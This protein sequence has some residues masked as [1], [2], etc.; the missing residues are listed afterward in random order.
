[1][2]ETR[3]YE[4]VQLSRLVPNPLNPRKSFEGKQFDELVASV[5]QKGV[6]EPIL[7]RPLNGSFEIV[8][9]ER[10]MKASLAAGIETIP[11]IIQTMS[12]DDAFEAMFIENLHREDLTP[13]EEAQGFKTYIDR[14]GKDALQELCERSGISSK[15][16]I[17]R[18]MILDLPEAALKLW[19]DGKVSLGHLEQLMRLSDKKS[20]NQ[21]LKVISQKD[22]SVEDLRRE[23][24]NDT[25]DLKRAKF[26]RK[27][28]GCTSCQQNSLLQHELFGDE[29][30]EKKSYCL[31]P[32]CFRAKQIAWFEE[33]WGSYA[34]EYN[35]NGFCFGGEVPYDKHRAFTAVDKPGDKCLECEHFVSM[36]NIDGQ[37][38]SGTEC[39]GDKSCF[40]KVTAETTAKAKAEGKSKD[41]ENAGGKGKGKQTAKQCATPSCGRSSSSEHG[42]FFREAFY[43]EALPEKIRA[44]SPSDLMA[45][46]ILLFALF[47]RV[48]EAR[49]HFCEK[50]NCKKVA[51][52]DEELRTLICAMDMESVERALHEATVSMMMSLEMGPSS[53]HGIAQYV[54]IDLQKEWRLNK[55]Y[56]E[57]KTIK[58]ML[59]LGK[60]LRIFSDDKALAYLMA[61]G[62]DKLDA[63]KKTEL[64]KVFLDSGVDL[65]GKVPDEILKA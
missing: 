31:N 26:D 54:G 29:S 30:T 64:I 24:N 35:T 52:S 2:Y 44:M 32:E 49:N 63:L 6:I 40:N 15:Y 39:V 41:K 53:R 3:T 51:S 10:R 5:S 36:I 46:Q 1:M 28:A 50:N 61:I 38:A 59:N 55:E 57:K 21:W 34:K 4:E 48:S 19:N 18:V 25:I 13:L 37:F 56:L 16:I 11:C 8:A 9:G 62:K 65:A 12:D 17:R 22:Y 33:N 45:R 58:E 20:I 60:K 43:K 7:V 27:A 47:R 23:I 14:K 42:Q